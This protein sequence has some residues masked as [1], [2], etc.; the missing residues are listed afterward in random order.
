MFDLIYFLISKLKTIDGNV[1][2]AK[3][4]VRNRI[5]DY[6]NQQDSSDKEILN[7]GL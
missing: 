6:I 1:G 7:D 3:Q 2:S 4:L 5:K